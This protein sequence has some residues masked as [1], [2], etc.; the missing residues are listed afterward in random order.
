[1][2]TA[3]APRQQLIYHLDPDRSTVGFSVKNMIFRTVHGR[4]TAFSGGIALD[5]GDPARSSVEVTI[6]AASIDTGVAK[7]DDH[8]RTQDFL[9]VAQI[10]HITFASTAVELLDPTQLRITGDLTIHGTT[11]RVVLEASAGARSADDQGREVASYSARTTIDRRDFG[12]TYGPSMMVGYPI[13][14]EIA[15]QAVL[16]AQAQP[17]A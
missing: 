11:R 15:V 16:Q 17:T 1:M 3:I 10:P 14:I 13:T 8:L 5:M 9:H 12:I 4:F 6:E 7:R 2:A